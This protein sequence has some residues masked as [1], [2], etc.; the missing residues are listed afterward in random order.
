MPC[1]RGKHPSSKAQRK[2]RGR[3]CIILD[4]SK[5]MQTRLVQIIRQIIFQLKRRFSSFRNFFTESFFFLVFG[6]FSG[7]F[8]GTFLSSIREV[9]PWDGFII[10][11]LLGGSEV[12]SANL[13]KQSGTP[14]LFLRSLNSWKIGVLLGF[15][16]DAFKVGS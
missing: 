13:L 3:F 4:F 9:L 5:I 2:E 1:K 16:I 14:S 7:N 11:V 10:I 15:F 8:F 6:F 12:I